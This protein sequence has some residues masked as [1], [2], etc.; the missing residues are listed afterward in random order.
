MDPKIRRMLLTAQKNEITEYHIYRKLAQSVKDD[1]NKEV[2]E[3]I[4]NEELK[5]YGIGKNIPGRMLNRVV[6]TV[7]VPFNLKKYSV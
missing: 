7:E 6:E 1:K 4:A 3:Q 2:L 5:H